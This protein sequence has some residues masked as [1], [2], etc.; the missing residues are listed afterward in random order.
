[1][2]PYWPIWYPIQGEPL[3]RIKLP[4]DLHQRAIFIGKV[5]FQLLSGTAHL[6]ENGV[7]H[8]SVKPVDCYCL[9]F[10][11][12][13]TK[14]TVRIT[15]SGHVFICDLY[16]AIICANMTATVQPEDS[17]WSHNVYY[18]DEILQSARQPVGSTINYT[19]ADSYAAGLVIQSLLDDNPSVK[20]LCTKLLPV[21]QGLL[22]KDVTTRVSASAAL[23]A[24]AE[25]SGPPS[26]EQLAPQ[27]VL[28]IHTTS[29]ISASFPRAPCN[30][31]KFVIGNK[32]SASKQP[33]NKLKHS[34]CVP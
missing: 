9:H 16:C 30:G 1:M 28:P 23:G 25:F 7:V 26:E 6:E 11:R 22:Q 10:R 21:V 33:D 4:E 13:I 3:S 29:T 15:E 27:F 12:C 2:A 17:D 34:M 5:A 8:R 18:P 19:K 14:E 20:P 31:T 24:L 32:C